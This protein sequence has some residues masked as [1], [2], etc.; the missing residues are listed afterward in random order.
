MFNILLSCVGRRAY[1]I[2]Y[3]KEALHGDGKVFATNSELTYALFQADGYAIA[4]LIYD[5]SYIDFLLGYCIENHIGAVV[6][7][8]D[9]DLPVL[10]KNKVRFEENGIKLIISNYEAIQICNDKWL[11]N[12][13]LQ[14]I[15]IK[16]PSTFIDEAQAIIAIESGYLSFPFVIKPRWGMGSLGVYEI[17]NIDEFRVLFLKLKKE[18][19]SSYLKYESC[20]DCDHCIIIQEKIFGQEY[21]IQILNDLN[22]QYVTTMVIKKLAMRAGETDIAITVGNSCFEPTAITVSQNLRHNSILDV[23]SIVNDAGDIIILDMNCRFGGQYPFTHMAGA[24]VPRQIIE[25][26]MDNETSSSFFSIKKDCL[27][28]KNIVPGIFK[29]ESLEHN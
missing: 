23:D 5:D 24:N 17:D 6:S 15:N 13:F 14:R 29:I 19:F 21:G 18:I 9:I 11:M 22:E 26:L 3:F 8:F 25:W 2:S 28:C 27:I 16:T 1:M 10:A 7:L 12:N 20:A 4:P